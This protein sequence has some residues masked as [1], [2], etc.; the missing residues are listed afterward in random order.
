MQITLTPEQADAYERGEPVTIERKKRVVVARHKALDRYIFL[1]EDARNTGRGFKGP[2]RVFDM[3]DKNN[4]SH[5]SGI[6]SAAVYDFAE[7]S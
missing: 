4:A 6:F 7:F 2:Y 3:K 5:S 1:I